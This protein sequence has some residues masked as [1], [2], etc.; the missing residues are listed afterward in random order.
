MGASLDSGA[1]VAVRESAAL[2]A[3]TLQVWLPC[4]VAEHVGLARA[5][6]TF[7]RVAGVASGG[8]RAYANFL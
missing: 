2:V 1:E 7:E 6:P 3:Q 5:D 8:P 4:D